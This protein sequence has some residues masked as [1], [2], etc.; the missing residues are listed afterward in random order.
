M[1]SIRE[2]L[3]RDLGRKIEEIIQVDQAEVAPQLTVVMSPI[4]R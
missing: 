3:E 4:A 1:N 2:L